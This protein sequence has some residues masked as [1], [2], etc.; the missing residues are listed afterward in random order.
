[1][2]GGPADTTVHHVPAAGG[3]VADHHHTPLHTHALIY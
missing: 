1:M 3:R 2:C